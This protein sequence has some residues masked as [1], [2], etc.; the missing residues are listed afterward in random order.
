MKNKNKISIN[1]FSGINIFEQFFSNSNVKKLLKIYKS[2]N[3]FHFKK[4]IIS[5]IIGLEL[6]F[7]IIFLQHSIAEISPVL[8]SMFVLPSIV[9]FIIALKMQKITFYKK[10]KEI[11]FP[12][13]F[14]E[15]IKFLQ[16]PES[17]TALHKI[18]NNKNLSQGDKNIIHNILNLDPNISHTQLVSQ[19]ELL[20]SVLYNNQIIFNDPFKHQL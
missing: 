4:R 2:I 20:K 13:L 11:I 19:L 10:R 15:I 17:Q 1:H 7:V 8:I 5:F 16:S 12:E 18:L 14:Q 6:F 3:Q 9:L